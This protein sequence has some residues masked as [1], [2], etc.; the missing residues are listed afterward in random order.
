MVLCTQKL[1]VP[2][3]ESYEM[4]CLLGQKYVTCKPVHSF[5]L[6]V[7]NLERFHSE[8]VCRL[9]CHKDPNLAAL[10]KLSSTN[11]NNRC[12]LLVDEEFTV[13]LLDLG[14]CVDIVWHFVEPWR[15]MQQRNLLITFLTLA[16]V[17]AAAKPVDHISDTCCCL[18]SS[19]TCWSHFWHLLLSVQ[20]RIVMNQKAQVCEE[21][22]SDYASTLQH[23]NTAQQ[24]H[25]YTTMP[26]VF[27][28]R[29]TTMPQVFQ[30]RAT[31]MPQAFQVRA[32]TMPQAFQVRASPP[33]NI[34]D[35]CSSQQFWRWIYSPLEPSGG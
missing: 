7:F 23:F 24:E 16:V 14:L 26:Q 22:K 28:V 31:T 1:K 3:A 29:A 4:L 19:K 17:C 12:F 10:W 35:G 11:K 2:F 15:G 8:T 32:T 34:G 25:F 33:K 30:V 20:H 27:Q 5:L 6:A 18:C 9:L 21:C 13:L